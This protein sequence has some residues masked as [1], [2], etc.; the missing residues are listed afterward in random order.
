MVVVAGRLVRRLFFLLLMVVMATGVLA[1]SPTLTTISEVRY[2]GGGRALA[3]IIDPQSIAAL[4]GNGDDGVRGLVRDIKAP[5]PRTSEDCENAALALLDDAGGSAWAGDYGTWSDFL[6]GNAA[7]IF[8]GDALVLSIPSRGANFQAVVRTVEI[9]VKDLE[10]E[11]SL[12]KMHF[13]DD[14]AEPLGFEF[15]TASVTNLSNINPIALTQVGN[16]F[17]S[18]LTGAEITQVSSTTSTID[19]GVL[20]QTGGGIEVRWTDAGWGPANDRNLAGRFS[21]QSFTVPRLSKSQTYYLRQY[22][23]SN[24]ARYSRYSTALHVDYPL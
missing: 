20:P 9:D 5:A 21:S 3:R 7:D 10:E 2:R 23:S 22:D 19:A 24:P 15:T 14:A 16:V 1:A 18:D 13:A 12:Y 6:P 4:A 11:H 17:L 8:P